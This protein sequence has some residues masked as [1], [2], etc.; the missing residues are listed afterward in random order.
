MTLSAP[1]SASNCVGVRPEIDVDLACPQRLHHGVGVRVVHVLDAVDLGSPSPEVR[2]GDQLDRLVLRVALQQERARADCVFVVGELK[3]IVDCRPDV[4]GHDRD[5]L[6]GV[7]RLRLLEVD[8]HGAVI[9]SL[10][11]IKAR[12]EAA[13]GGAHCRHFHHLVVGPLD[14]FGGERLAVRPRPCPRAA[15]TSRSVPS[16]LVSHDSASPSVGEPSSA[17]FCTRLSYM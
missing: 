15:C 6:A 9:G 3:G 12:D 14:V 7:G 5:L 11:G 1:S 13:I 2:V 17:S 4:L 16:S 8:D 10:D